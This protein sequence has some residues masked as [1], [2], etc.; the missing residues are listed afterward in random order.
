MQLAI[1]NNSHR[2]LRQKG[3]SLLEALVAILLMAIVGLAITYNL[4]KGTYQQGKLNA[5]TAVL[6]EIRGQLQSSGM[7][8]SC[9]TAGAT[10][11]TT[12]KLSNANSSAESTITRSCSLSLMSVSVNSSSKTVLLPVVSY[13]VTDERLGS[14]SFILQ[15]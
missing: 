15:N 1:L 2:L 13:T 11:Q 12:V 7:N 3:T 10:T 6:N 9:T 4:A 8:S 14:S 5:Q